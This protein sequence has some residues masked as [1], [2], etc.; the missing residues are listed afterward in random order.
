MDHGF[1]YT[2]TEEE[3]NLQDIRVKEPSHNMQ[4]LHD[5]QSFYDKQPLHDLHSP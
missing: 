3:M 1:D 2:G 5:T 4:H